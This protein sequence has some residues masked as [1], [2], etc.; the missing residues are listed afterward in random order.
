MKSVLPV[1]RRRAALQSFT[2]RCC[3]ALHPE[4]EPL[5]T[6]DRIHRTLGEYNFAGQYQQ[7][8]E[9]LGGGLVKAE[10]FK[11]YRENDRPERFER[12][13]QS[14]DNARPTN[15]LTAYDLHLRALP[16]AYAWEREGATLRRRV[17][18]CARPRKLRA[19]FRISFCS[20]CFRLERSAGWPCTHRKS[21]ALSRRVTAS[22]L[23]SNHQLL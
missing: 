13:V 15:D 23:G 4:R 22:R 14:W 21:A 16:H 17:K 7:S 8:P 10:W 2:R 12:I 5:A 19:I 20:D 6:L 18:N 3:E 9:P 11:R 1:W